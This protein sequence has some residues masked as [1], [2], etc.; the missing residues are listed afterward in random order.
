MKPI[1]DE[2]TGITNGRDRVT[3]PELKKPKIRAP[4]A[5]TQLTPVLLKKFNNLPVIRGLSSI[6]LLVE[7]FKKEHPKITLGNV[8]DLSKKV[9]GEYPSNYESRRRDVGKMQKLSL[10][11][12]L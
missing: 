5:A 12:F 4:S 10:R 9:T 2:K 3:P 6:G 8:D 11:L 1:N 7:N